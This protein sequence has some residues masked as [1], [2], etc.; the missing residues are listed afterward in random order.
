MTKESE[1]GNNFVSVLNWILDYS[2]YKRL[3]NYIPISRKKMIED[4]EIHKKGQGKSSKEE[5]W[6]NTNWN[7]K[8]D[9]VRKEN[10]STNITVR[11]LL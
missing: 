9:I 1:R 8:K 3:G 10:I 5:K 7:W 2:I 11:N 4:H 6:E